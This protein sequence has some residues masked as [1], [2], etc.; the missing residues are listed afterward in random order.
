M[1]FF[2]WMDMQKGYLLL[3]NGLNFEG[4][5]PEWQQ[6]FFSGEVVFTTGMTGYFESLTD[7]SFA[8]QILVFTFP[9]I[10]NYGVPGVEFWESKKIHAAGVVISE[11]C[12]NWSHHAG[13]MSLLEWLKLQRVP[14]ISNVDTRA[15]TKILREKGCL[16][17]AI[18][19]QNNQPLLLKD[20]NLEHLVKQVSIQ[21]TQKSGTGLKK[22]IAVDCGMKESM[23]RFLSKYPIEITRVPYNFDY[24]DLDYDGVFLSN[25]PGDPIRCEETIAILKKAMKKEKPIF[26]VCL[27]SQMMALAAGAK[28]YKLRYGHRGQNQPCMELE[29]GKCFITS[30]NHG[31][32]VDEETLPKEWKVMFKNL[33]D[34]S[35]EGIV[36]RELPFFSVQFHPEACPGPTDTRWLFERFYQCL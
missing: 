28:T 10:G 5:C 25:G 26:G 23:M 2:F 14:L 8:G 32:A 33:N 29:S 22:I 15:I 27:G 4:F 7:P 21:K 24:T 34:G 17:G 30:Q 19:H 9:L 3:E 16:L 36:H 31:F 6:N 13:L 11:S 12:L 18:S 1:A 35:V 20:P